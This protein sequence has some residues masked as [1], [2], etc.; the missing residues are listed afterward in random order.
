MDPNHSHFILVDDGS[1]GFF[2]REIDFRTKL[3]TELRK[4]KDYKSSKIRKESICEP[5]EDE[6]KVPIILIVVQG[7]KNTLLTIEKAVQQLIPILVIAVKK[8]FNN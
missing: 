2:G 7:G 5:N 8:K 3:E 4:G 6:F 1:I